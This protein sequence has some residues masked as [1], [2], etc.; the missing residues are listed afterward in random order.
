[1]ACGSDGTNA[2]SAALIADASLNLYGTT[3]AG[4]GTGCG[5]LGCGTVFELTPAGSE[6]VLHSFSGSDGAN[7]VGGLIADASGALYGTTFNGGDSQL[8]TVFK[9]TVPAAFSGVP[10]QA[11]CI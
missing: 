9:L 2:A 7:P 3:L 11:N 10:G 1:F 5:D 4:G 6:S 8:G